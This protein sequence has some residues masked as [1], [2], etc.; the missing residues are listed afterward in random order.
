MSYEA[1]VP[2]FAQLLQE[3][4]ETGMAPSAEALATAR[5]SIA[6]SGT[7]YIVITNTQPNAALVGTSAATL[8][9][10]TL[11]Q[12]SDVVLCAIPSQR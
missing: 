7:S 2:S 4:G 1:Q 10:C 9:G 6:P 8:T 12:V 3:V 11:K 5:A